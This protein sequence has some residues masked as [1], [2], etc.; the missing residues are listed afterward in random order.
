MALRTEQEDTPLQNKLNILADWI[1]KVGAGAALLLFMVLFIKFCAQ[2][3]HNYGTPSEKGQE[4]VEIVIVSVTVVVMAVPEGLPLA[5]TLALSFATVKMLRDNNLVRILKACEAMG[6][7]TTICSDKTGTLTQNKMTAVATTL[8]KAISF[9]STDAPMDKSLKIDQ[10]AITVPNVSE[11]EFA[12][13][14]SPEVKGL[15]IQSNALNSTALEGEQDGQK[16][17]IGSKTGVALLSYCRDHLGADPIE[18]TRSSADVVQSVPFDNK[19]SAVVVKLFDG[20]YQVYTK[21]TSE[22]L[23]GK[24][25]RTLGNISKGEAHQYH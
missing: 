4:F 17:F 10:E 16:T 11:A 2:L 1:A 7:A 19:Y 24:C 9:G 14:L 15:L 20:K 3:P 18:E 21:G 25:T 8:G 6:N 23:L 22:I 12:N 13:G 5:V